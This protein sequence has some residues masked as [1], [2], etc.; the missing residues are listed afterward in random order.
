MFIIKILGYTILAIVVMF[1]TYFLY[2]VIAA[3]P[4]RSRNKAFVKKLK[5]DGYVKKLFVNWSQPNPRNDGES[6]EDYRERFMDEL[7]S[8][9]DYSSWASN[10]MAEENEKPTLKV[11]KKVEKKFPTE[12]DFLDNFR[13]KASQDTDSEKYFKFKKFKENVKNIL[14]TNENV[15]ITIYP[16]KYDTIEKQEAFGEWRGV[17]YIGYWDMFV[18]NAVFN[19]VDYDGNGSVSSLSSKGL[20]EFYET[21][22]KRESLDELLGDDF[23]LVP[24]SDSGA[25]RENIKIEWERPL[26]EQ[27]FKTF[28]EYGGIEE[29]ASETV[30][31]DNDEVIIGRISS[32]EIIVGKESFKIEIL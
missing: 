15:F 13:K 16:Y 11:S 7:Y 26:T 21:I 22:K 23:D 9:E 31:Y 5:E 20:K 1:I 24:D 6:F 8:Q 28:E 2:Q 19:Y 30:D 27:E 10:L 25:H 18:K 12:K 29:L 14:N 32:I 17:K 3:F 4:I